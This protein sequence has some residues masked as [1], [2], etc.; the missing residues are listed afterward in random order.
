MSAS[1][2]YAMTMAM[3]LAAGLPVNKAL[4]STKKVVSNYIYS[5]AISEVK[6]K[7][8]QGRS[9]SQARKENSVFPTMLIEMSAVGE[10][11]G[12][13]EET[14][15]VVGDYFANEVDIKANR[16][17]A[18]MEP[19]ITLFITIFVVVLL[20]AVYLPMFSMYGEL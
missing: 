8:E 11:S 6:Y 2:D 20:M 9:I 16:L 19:I 4:E 18:L 10:S 7:V 15:E 5:M 12:S 1:K 13:L 3:L 17:L 14:Y